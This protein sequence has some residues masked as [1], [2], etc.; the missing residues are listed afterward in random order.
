MLRIVAFAA[1]LIMVTGAARAQQPP[2]TPAPTTPAPTTSTT[3]ATATP[4]TPEQ[5]EQSRQEYAA[6]AGAYERGDYDVALKHF[7]AAYQ[8]APSPELWFNIGRCHERLGRWAE[9]ATAYERYLAGKPTVEDAVQIRERISDLRLR[10][11]EAARL[12]Q[13]PP[14]VVLPPPPAPAPPP[15]SLRAPAIALGAVTVALAAGGVGTWFSEWSDYQSRKNACQGTCSA[16]SLDGLRTRVQTA[17]VAAA[18]LW[19]VAG[20]AL[21]ADVTLWILDARRRH[22]ERPPATASAA[23]FVVRF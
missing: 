1:T 5:F 18:A 13:A 3:P 11:H 10:A 21:V 19:A 6:A 22:G 7:Q 14:P 8:L 2:T 16:A 20:A 9:A 4:T 12:V 23:D 15:R 17:E